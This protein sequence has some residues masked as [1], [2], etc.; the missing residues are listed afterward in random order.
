[1]TVLATIGAAA[2]WITYG[3]LLCGVI[4][5]YLAER[6]GYPTKLGL[7]LGLLTLVIGVLVMLALPARP[8]SLWK[9]VG[10]FGRGKAGEPP[11]AA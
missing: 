7:A 3:W 11:K 9:A 5:S 8:G 6:K 1:M 10:P 4:G 2:L